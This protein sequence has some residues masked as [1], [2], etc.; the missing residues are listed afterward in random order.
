MTT[1]GSRTSLEVEGR[2]LVESLRGKWSSNGSG[3]GGMCCCPAHNDTSPSLS[4]RV[5]DRSLLFHCFA[6]CETID[7][8]RAL[9]RGGQVGRD[10]LGATNEDR[11]KKAYT[12]SGMALRLWD[13]THPVAGTLA[14][15][16]LEYRAISMRSDQLRF[17]P[18]AQLG[19][20]ADARFLPALIA[21]IRDDCGLVA[22]H[23]TFLDEKTG[24]KADIRDP[25]RLLGRPG[26]GAVRLQPAGETL[27]LAE[28]VETAMSASERLGFPVW[29]VVGNER[30]GIVSIPPI[31]RRLVILPDPDNGGRRAWQL[32]AQRSRVAKTIELLLPPQAASN[33]KDDWNAIAMRLRGEK[34][35]AD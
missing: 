32:A 12:D 8:I 23:R 19:S 20:K 35:A 5:G 18:R 16:Y 6:G 17:H 15:A 25:K 9:R 2:D 22:V 33:G 30:F 3:G 26:T 28:G 27:G 21:A 24:W 4:V 7:V 31:V 34:A 29:A 10:G 11:P 14:E 1:V 13:T